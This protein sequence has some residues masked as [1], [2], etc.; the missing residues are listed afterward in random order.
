MSPPSRSP[1]PEPRTGPIL[2]RKNW[3]WV[4]IDN[5][6]LLERERIRGVDVFRTMEPAPL[7]YRIVISAFVERAYRIPAVVAIKNERDIRF[8]TAPVEFGIL[9]PSERK[10]TEWLDDLPPY[11][12]KDVIRSNPDFVE[13]KP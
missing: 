7:H 3:R 5:Y 10:V 4:K 11:G 13:F 8:G 2:R 6:P 1:E 12:E 9:P